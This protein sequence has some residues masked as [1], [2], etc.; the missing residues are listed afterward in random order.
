MH[1]IEELETGITHHGRPSWWDGRAISLCEKRFSEKEYRQ[2]LIDFGVDC[3]DC[4]EAKRK[5]ERV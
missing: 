5:G 1:D 4:K 2:P 3:A